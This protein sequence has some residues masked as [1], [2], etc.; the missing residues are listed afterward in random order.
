MSSGRSGLGYLTITLVAACA[1]LPA[2]GCSSQTELGPAPESLA[3]DSVTSG[4]SYSEIPKDILSGTADPKSSK[5]SKADGPSGLG[6]GETESLNTSFGSNDVE[7]SIRNALRLAT[8]GERAKAAELLD[9][10]LAVE[11]INREALLGRASIAFEDSHQA[12]TPAESAVLLDKAVGLLRTLIRA[13]ETP[14]ANEIEMLARVLYEKAQRLVK[15]GHNDQAI[16]VLRESSAAGFDAFAPI[17]IDDKMAAL[18]QSPEYKEE[19]KTS[20]AKRLALAKQRVQDRLDKPIEVPLKFALND[21]DGKPVTLSDFKGKIVV[22]DFWGTWCGPCREAIPFLCG[23]YRLRHG[24]G[25][26]ILGLAYERGV[27]DD[28]E[29]RAKVKEFAKQAD[30]PYTC[31]IGTEDVLAQIPNFKGFPTS[32]VLDQTGKVRV[33][34]TENEKNTPVFIADVVE[35]L[36]AEKTSPVQASTKQAP[37]QA[38]AK[39]A[40]AQATPKKP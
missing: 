39:N 2:P 31:L 19:I 25:L 7:R 24:R 33:L 21:L 38:T 18:R 34:V 1:A 32:V 35:I 5:A 10:V 9:K 28:K 12:K 14:K 23:L 11:P 27:A 26:E 17:E 40:P 6:S 4:G 15:E 36:L 16:A 30:I 20:E 8:R 3:H 13:H 37:A 29:A 22:L